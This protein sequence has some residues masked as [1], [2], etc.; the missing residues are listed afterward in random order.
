MD[1]TPA[2]VSRDRKFAETAITA[3]GQVLHAVDEPTFQTSH[4]HATGDDSSVD[5]D[6]DV[7]ERGRLVLDNEDLD[8]PVESRDD[9]VPTD[10]P[11]TPDEMM[12]FERNVVQGE[13][14]SKRIPEAIVPPHPD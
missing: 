14:K 1:R 5:T 2:D 7:V 4:H 12:N 10:R 13:G 8:D 11:L 3:D 6:P 9:E